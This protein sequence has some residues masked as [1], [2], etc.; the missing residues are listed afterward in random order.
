MRKF[1]FINRIE[2]ENPKEHLF[3]KIPEFIGDRYHKRRDAGN[4]VQ[5]RSYFKCTK[6]D[7]Y[8]NRQNLIDKGYSVW[9]E[10]AIGDNLFVTLVNGK[11]QVHLSYLPHV[12]QITQTVEEQSTLPI[13][14]EDNV[15][16]DRGFEPT[17][18]QIYSDY[19][20]VDC[21]MSYAIQLCD[22]S[23]VIIDGGWSEFGDPERLLEFMISKLP[24]GE[25]PVIAA[26]ILTHHHPDHVNCFKEYAKSYQDK[27]EVQSIIYNNPA[28]S[29]VK[30]NENTV[31]EFEAI[32]RAV[33]SF[34]E[35]TKLYNPHIGEV[36]HIR[37]AR[38]ECYFTQEDL[39]S[40]HFWNT[41]NTSIVFKME[42]GNSKVLWLGDVGSGA[43]DFLI[44]NY[45]DLLEADV[46]QI[47]HHGY[48]DAPHG[49]YLYINAKT[50]LW[51]IP[52]YRTEII[53]KLG[54]FL[55]EKC[56]CEKIYFSHDKTHTIKV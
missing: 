20:K 10:N 5:H 24:E 34:P 43:S 14:P 35:T 31:K 26:W 8:T 16:T 6:D 18:T 7:F 32:E 50:A 36:F 49:L 28:L 19:S 11:Y 37:N 46:V 52:D 2:D 51:P 45:F 22:G 38:F 42:L 56:N 44:N 27:V 21:A 4:N 40:V 29:R 48:G 3:T 12:R 9:Q 30:S 41:N 47:A 55:K 25:K 13:R 33:E 17:V 15:Y 1:E 53:E 23:F 54:G 39:E